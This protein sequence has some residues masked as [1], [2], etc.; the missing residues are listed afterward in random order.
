MPLGIKWLL[1]HHAALF[2]YAEPHKTR[3]L[4]MTST[5]GMQLVWEPLHLRFG[6]DRSHTD[7]FLMNKHHTS[8]Q[9]M[10][11]HQIINYMIK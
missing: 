10:I 4:L 7:V 2:L 9:I 5:V 8:L 1:L 3:L 6:A 11:H